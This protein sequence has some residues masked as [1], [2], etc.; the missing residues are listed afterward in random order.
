MN[1]SQAPTD[2]VKNLPVTVV[3]RGAHLGAEIS[4]AGWDLARMDSETKL[5]MLWWAM[6]TRLGSTW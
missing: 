5:W 4:G 3:K 1:A 2:K 6:Q